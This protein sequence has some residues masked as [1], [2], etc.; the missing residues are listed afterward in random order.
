M[1]NG[2]SKVSSGDRMQPRPCTQELPFVTVVLAIAASYHVMLAQQAGRWEMKQN[3]D[4][5]L[6][7]SHPKEGGQ[8]WG[9]RQCI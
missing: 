4:V 8:Q 3:G 2:Q 7:V 5:C 6:D 9:F 1:D